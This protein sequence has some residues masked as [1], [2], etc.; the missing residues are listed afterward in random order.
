M[1]ST[2]RERVLTIISKPLQ[3]FETLAR[4]PS[5]KVLIFSLPYGVPANRDAE[6]KGVAEAVFAYCRKLECIDAR[7]E[8][9]SVG[10][11]RRY[12]RSTEYGL[13]VEC[14]PLSERDEEYLWDKRHLFV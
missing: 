7:S 8:M 11:T 3:Y 4:M 5:L 1:L 10:L 2:S 14:R 9:H 13:N 6:A 12:T